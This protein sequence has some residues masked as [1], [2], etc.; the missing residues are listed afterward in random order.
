[1]DCFLFTKREHKHTHTHTH[2]YTHTRTHT[3]VHACVYVSLNVNVICTLLCK[4]TPCRRLFINCLRQFP[5][6]WDMSVNNAGSLN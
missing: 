6:R 5:M 4:F 1:M 2:T 3:H